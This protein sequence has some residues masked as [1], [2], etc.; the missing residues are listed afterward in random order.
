MVYPKFFDNIESI[1]MYDPLAE[2]L[3]CF[4]KGQIEFSYKDIV[5]AAGHSCPTVAGAYLMCQQGL[6]LLYPEQIPV[7]GQLKVEFKET[8]EEGV[9][10]V[11]ASVFT[12]I[13]GA[14]D[15]SGFKGINGQF[16]RHSLM[17]FGSP[18]QSSVRLS[19]ID[20]QTTVELLYSPHVIP[21]SAEQQELIALIMQNSASEQQKICFGQLWQERVEKILCG[22]F[23]DNGILKVKA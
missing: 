1:H 17:D 16:T 10:G 9:A 14:T 21:A 23:F 11:I 12:H 8:L 7:R 15:T 13:T 3:G 5:K 2:F 20:N 4:S 18:I 6:K 22:S 19:R